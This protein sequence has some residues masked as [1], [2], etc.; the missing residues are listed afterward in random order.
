MLL[1]FDDFI[2]YGYMFLLAKQVIGPEELAAE[3]REEDPDSLNPVEQALQSKQF[4]FFCKART[5][6]MRNFLL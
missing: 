5:K 6:S 4:F 3:L 2:L 1:K